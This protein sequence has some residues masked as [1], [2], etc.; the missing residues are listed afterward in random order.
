MVR[1]FQGPLQ[2]FLIRVTNSETLDQ[3][4]VLQFW[5]TS[6]LYS[7]VCWCFVCEMPPATDIMKSS[8]FQ[9]RNIHTLGEEMAHFATIK[10]AITR[11]SS[12]PQC[13]THEF[14]VIINQPIPFFGHQFFQMLF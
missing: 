13:E 10:S 1:W 6:T 8:V 7:F 3:T 9:Q 4:E 11:I 2:L 5:K 14:S 12:A